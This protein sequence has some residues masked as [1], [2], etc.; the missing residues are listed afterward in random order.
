MANNTPNTT[1]TT[2]RANTAAQ[3]SATKQAKNLRRQKHNRAVA[4]KISA[5][6]QAKN[7]RR[8]FHSEGVGI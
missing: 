4:R 6:K 7:L 1:L 3:I 2:A 5:T 8:A